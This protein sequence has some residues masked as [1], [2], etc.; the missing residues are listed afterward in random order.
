MKR[1]YLML[2]CLCVFAMS[3]AQKIASFEVNPTHVSNGIQMPVSVDLDAVTFLPDSVLQLVEVQGSKRIPVPYQV[4]STG[5]RVLYWQVDQT[6]DKAQKHVYELIKGEA[7]PNGVAGQAKNSFPVISAKKDTGALTIGTGNRS[8]LS[9]YYLTRYPPKGVDTAYR[10]SGFIHPLFS[11][12]GQVLTRIQAPDHYHH[13]GLW[14]P[15]THV[16]YQK[17]TIDFWNLNS[18]QGTVRFAKFLS[19]NDGP[20]FSEYKVLHEHVVLKKGPASGKVA[21]NEVQTVRIYQPNNPDYY[22][23]DI[24]SELNCAD[25]SEVLLLEYRYGGLGWR[26]TEEW[27]NKN[28]EV[29]TSEGKTRK[30]ADGTTARWCIVQGKLS[31]DYGGLEMMSYPGNYNH[32]E[33]LRVWPENQF[34]RGD[35]YANFDPT[36][37]MNWLLKPGHTYTLHYRFLVFNGHFTKEKAESAWQNYST[38]PAVQVKIEK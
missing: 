29:L 33:P 4:Q 37:N 38:P 24:T 32:P 9:Y 6:G 11:P 7:R 27:D 26:T 10:R 34:V 5:K 28:S 36:K 17:D 21:M 16:L 25:T 20:V 14:N 18:K 35:M 22:I 19:M 1:I 31:N 13:Y 23:M 2:F 15:W 3:R 30:D 12:H 8:F